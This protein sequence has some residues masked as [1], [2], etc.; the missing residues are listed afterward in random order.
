MRLSN[1]YLLFIQRGHDQVCGIALERIDCMIAKF[2]A[3]I[4]QQHQQW[5]GTDQYEQNQTRSQAG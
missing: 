5:K 3:G 4:D 1:Q 2:N